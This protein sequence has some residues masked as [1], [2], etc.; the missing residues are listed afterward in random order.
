M[1]LHTC[2]VKRHFV[3]TIALQV[4]M[5]PR[6]SLEGL[7]LGLH[8]LEESGRLGN[9]ISFVTYRTWP[10][11]A[12]NS[13]RPKNLKVTVDKQPRFPVF[14]PGRELRKAYLFRSHPE[15][16]FATPHEQRVAVA[17]NGKVSFI[18]RGYNLGKGRG[19]FFFFFFFSWISSGALFWCWPRS[20]AGSKADFRM[21]YVQQHH[22]T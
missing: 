4:R 14:P 16:L 10:S 3:S 6:G 9:N 12:S 19:L 1:F 22:C 5:L 20:S 15:T 13:P 17:C 8:P 18:S 11:Q 2:S 7:G 21:Q